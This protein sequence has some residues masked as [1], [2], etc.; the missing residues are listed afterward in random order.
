MQ[1]GTD[2]NKKRASARIC[3]RLAKLVRREKFDLVHAHGNSATMFFDMAGAK[4]GGC[5]I[6]IAHGR[7]TS[8]GNQKLD[9]LLRP[10]F[11]HSYTQA[12]ACREKGGRM[13]VCWKKIPDYSKWKRTGGI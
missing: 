2:R 4:L 1:A 3:S 13:V 9:R 8:C 11:Y 12:A 7:S 6:R 10:F 5:R